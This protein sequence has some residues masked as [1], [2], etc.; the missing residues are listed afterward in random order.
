[1]YIIHIS[2]NA[3]RWKMC[4]SV[5]HGL[6]KS[7]V[8][9]YCVLILIG[10]RL[11]FHLFAFFISRAIDYLIILSNCSDDTCF[12]T[13]NGCNH[14]S[15]LSRRAIGTL[16]SVLS[17]LILMIAG[18]SGCVLVPYPADVS[19]SETP[20]SLLTPLLPEQGIVLVERS[21]DCI[22]DRLSMMTPPVR[23][24][25]VASM[26]DD[27]RRLAQV[28]HT[29]RLTSEQVAQAFADPAARA[30]VDDQRIIYAVV[31][32]Y[33][34][35]PTSGCDWTVPLLASGW[36]VSDELR[37]H[38]FAV[39]IVEDLGQAIVV[40]GGSA[41]AVGVTLCV[42][43]KNNVGMGVIAFPAWREGR[44]CEQ[45]ATILH[46]YFLSIQEKALQ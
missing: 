45:M 28:E 8:C 9:A 2:Q 26:P 44:A 18:L 32:S 38:V 12:L 37:A 41:T 13:E 14:R 17:S 40:T 20:A 35:A 34:D 29:E 3:G 1:M 25:P 22:A 27:F 5:M 16:S 15:A 42:R 39:P 23:L 21:P 36:Q 7:I 24:I 46:R 31:V 30:V 4:K 6:H 11:Y 43:G 19:T 10:F 33:V